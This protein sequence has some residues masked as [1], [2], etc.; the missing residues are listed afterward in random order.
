MRYKLELNK[1]DLKALN[2]KVGQLEALN[3]KGLSGAIKKAAATASNTAK[4]KAPVDTG[5]LR[6]QIGFERSPDGKGVVI[7]SNAPYS[8]YV[9][10]G[11]RFQRE[12]P[13]FMPAVRVAVKDL[14][15]DLDRLIKKAVR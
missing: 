10:F 2:R 7:F 8:G 14:I 15:I 13:Y 11:T 1:G 3:K 12:Q 5:N 6:S 9:E 4:R